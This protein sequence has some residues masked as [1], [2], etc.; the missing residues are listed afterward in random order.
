VLADIYFGEFL[1]PDLSG[2]GG[3]GIGTLIM[4]LIPVLQACGHQVRVFQSARSPFVEDYE[5]AKVIGI[6]PLAGLGKSNE[7]VVKLFR[8]IAAASSEEKD[9]IE[10]FAADFF[11]VWNENPLAIAIQNGIAWDASFHMEGYATPPMAAW[12]EK[13]ARWRCQERGLRRFERCYNRVVVDLYFLNW[14]RSFRGPDY[15]GRVYYNP[16]PAPPAP[17]DERR[18]RNDPQK[19]V[20]V[21]MARRMVPEKGTRLAAKVF[22][23]V[24][25]LRPGVQ[26]TFAGEG[27]E[28]SFLQDAFKDEPRVGFTVFPPQQA[29]DS[30][31]DF[32]IAVIPSLCG[33]ATCL[34][35]LEAMAAGCAVVA[36]NMGG[37]ITQ[38]QDGYSGRLCQPEEQALFEALMD[39]IDRPEERLSMAK[40]GWEISQNVFPL[41]AW[42]E[43]WK[44]ILRE[45][46]A[47]RDLAREEIAKSWRPSL[48]ERA[49][50]VRLS[51]HRKPGAVELEEMARY[52]REKYPTPQ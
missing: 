45:V 31:R 33:E 42:Q 29:V 40:R 52:F 49:Q 13:L 11:S 30:H 24:L 2:V 44:A 41:A 47:G 23:R 8:D 36:T 18:D 7:A 35:V 37:T 16:N 22:M 39:L 51:L 46:V 12:K 10:L 32:D 15:P 3:G 1:K 5:G 38:I 28:R 25:A 48:L 50:Q 4:H 14:Y 19:P 20:R 26:V 9:R 21:I 6:P 17:W 34:A 43:R 27:P